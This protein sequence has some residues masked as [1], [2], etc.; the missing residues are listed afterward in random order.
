MGSSPSCSYETTITWAEK[1]PSCSNPGVFTIT[2]DDPAVDASI[3]VT[4]QSMD[5]LGTPL[6]NVPWMIYSSTQGL[7]A[8]NSSGVTDDNGQDT[9]L[10]GNAGFGTGT[11]TL[12]LVLDSGSPNM[13]TT[14]SQIDWGYAPP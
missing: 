1:I 11:D 6:P 9:I 2:P 13:C 10:L 8:W 12:V 5:D 14:I 4:I 3:T 7:D